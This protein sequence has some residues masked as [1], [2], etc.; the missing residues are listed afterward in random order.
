VIVEV[1]MRTRDDAISLSEGVVK[2][3][4]IWELDEVA[5]GEEEVMTRRV[6]AEATATKVL[7]P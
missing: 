4:T 6:P 7:L 2:L 3:I 5:V 1:A